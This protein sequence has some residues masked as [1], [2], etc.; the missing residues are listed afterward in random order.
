[1]GLRNWGYEDYNYRYTYFIT[2]IKVPTYYVP[3][4]LQVGSEGLPIF[5]A[6]RVF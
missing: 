2:P 3:M 4:I 5:A 6:F 1:M